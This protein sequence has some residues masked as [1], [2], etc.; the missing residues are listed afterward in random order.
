MTH[1]LLR[2]TIAL[3]TL[4]LLAGCSTQRDHVIFVTKT[5]LGVDVA[6]QPSGATIGYERFEG[7]VGPRFDNGGVPPVVASFRSNGELLFREVRQVYATGAAAEK[8]TGADAKAD[9]PDP[10]SNDPRRMHFVTGTSVG[11][12]LGFG[13]TATTEFGFG[14]KRRE[15]SVI[16]VASAAS[17]AKPQ[18]PSVFASLQNDVAG[19][20]PDDTSFGVGQFFATGTAA[21]KLAGRKDAKALLLG[22]EEGDTSAVGTARAALG[23]LGCLQDVPD[24]QLALVWRHAKLTEVLSGAKDFDLDKSL[25]NESNAATARANYARALTSAKWTAGKQTTALAQHRAVVCGI[26][27]RR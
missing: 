1:A 13:S 6:T 16:P 8:V 9:A 24:N 4:A 19:Q 7:Y 15:M 27:G 23:A 11:L 25:T 5:T 21:V 14:Y 18:F 26:A 12:R 17:S 3:G 20:S 10:S 2:N 22:D